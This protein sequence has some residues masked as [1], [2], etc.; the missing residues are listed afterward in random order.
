MKKTALVLAAACFGLI[1]STGVFAE[2]R[3]DINIAI[4]SD[5]ES[6]HPSDWNTTNEKNIGD[7]IY[8]TLLYVP[9]DGN[10]E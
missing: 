4:D 8:D 2:G 3:T 7:Q 6:L 10:E 9:M 5:I 1:M